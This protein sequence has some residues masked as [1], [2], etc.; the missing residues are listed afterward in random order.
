MTPATGVLDL[1]VS[2][3]DTYRLRG[4][5][6]D[7]QQGLLYVMAED[8]DASSGQGVLT[9]VD[10]PNR[11]VRASVP[12]PLPFVETPTVILSADGERLYVA[13][14]DQESLT[15]IHTGPDS[16]GK[17]LG[18]VADV[19]GVALDGSTQRL[20]VVGYSGLR[21]LDA[22]TL[23]QEQLVALPD[24]LSGMYTRW[25][26]VNES[27]RLLYVTHPGAE[28]IAAY[29]LED[30][31][32]VAA[33]T[34]GG[35]LRSLVCAPSEGAAYALMEYYTPLGPASRVVRLQG[36]R[37]AAQSW[38]AEPGWNIV[39]IVW[40]SESRH[41]LLL[42][43]STGSDVPLSRV[44]VMDAD[45]DQTLQTMTL[46]RLGWSEPG[47]PQPFA[48][49]GHL[50]TPG[51][52]LVATDLR[53]GLS[54][55]ILV[56]ITLLSAALDETTDRLFVADSAGCIRVV[57]PFSLQEIANWPEVLE[58]GPA[59][60][61]P[62]A[63]T[64]G[65]GRLYVSDHSA[66]LTLVLDATTGARLG[67]IPKAGQVSLDL[68]HRRLFITRDGVYVADERT[69]QITHTIDET[70]RQDPL[71]IAPSAVQ[72]Q[73][74]AQRDLL[75]VTMSNNAPGSSASTW[76][77]VYEGTTLT[78]LEPPL[79]IGAQ[80]LQGIALSQ[81]PDLL[82]LAALT[83]RAEL[84]ALTLDGTA[85]FHLPGIAGPLFS[86]QM[87]QHIHV[88]DWEGWVT[89]DATSG[90]VIA[91]NAVDLTNAS[92]A[93]LDARHNR[94]YAN[95]SANA[96]LVAV[97]PS[98]AE[99]PLIEEVDELPPQPI[100]C[101]AVGSDGT[102]LAVSGS[103]WGPATRSAVIGICRPGSHR[104]RQ[105]S[106]GLPTRAWPVVK[107]APGAPGVFF[108]FSAESALPYGI[109]RSTD[110][111]QT[112]HAAM[113]GLTDLR[114]LDV[115][116]SPN[117]G[118]DKTAMLLAG[119]SGLFMTSDAGESWIR[120]SALACHRVAIAVGSSGALEALF[121]A[122]DPENPAVLTVFSAADGLEKIE[123]RGWIARAS[124]APIHALVLSPNW[125]NDG[126]ALAGYPLQLSQDG[127]R[128]WRRVGPEPTGAVLRCSVIFSPGFAMDRTVYGLVLERL[129]GGYVQ[130]SLLRSTDGG[131][132][133]EKAAE[134]VSP[135]ISALGISR[136]GQ[137]WTGDDQG[138]V[139]ILNPAQVTWQPV[140]APTPVPPSPVPP[141]PVPTPGG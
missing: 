67:A 130:R 3:A 102:I 72:A 114:V 132:S 26:F 49:R 133:W 139:A 18:S 131:Q 58:A 64:A 51:E 80:S 116:L 63:L 35:R 52:T 66:D 96:D 83:P 125:G 75:F 41:L 43:E 37:L 90:E 82:W 127:G 47:N 141:T 88:A 2:P 27:A 46:P 42:E 73:Y 104:W 11:Q 62:V 60:A 138:T 92:F 55:R 24:T 33:I 136:D 84:V 115:A 78:R 4:A 10:L 20:Y 1:G 105:V 13:A 77:Q 36:E 31:T 17:M 111:G 22:M 122:E 89:I 8:G 53:T 23:A 135:A 40:D 39:H 61:S 120:V 38:E 7:S 21:R 106:G 29:R 112:W 30:L 107:A 32:A 123:P 134:L 100:Q 19:V 48:Y 79:T 108:A 129:Y 117:F 44:R 87:G 119:D 113:R 118:Q 85:R 71:Q 74:D 93:I 126:T 97:D 16:L 5:A 70:V 50:Y 99:P 121:I 128:S 9:V 65:G 57:D 14:P 140:P 59:R 12:L 101:L 81:Q 28:L 94:L 45:T 69:Y 68:G 98:V 91:Y 6:L 103:Q 110:Y 15:V 137:L 109:M 76:V 124:G 56:G 86:S 34:P 25:L 54:Q 95:V